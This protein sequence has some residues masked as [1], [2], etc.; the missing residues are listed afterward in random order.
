MKWVCA[1]D[2][3]Q[4]ISPGCSFTFDGLKET[5]L[6]LQPGIEGALSSVSHLSVNYRTTKD[7][8]LLGNEI[9]AVAK[10]TFPN[11]IGFASPEVSRKDLGFK[12]ILCSWA[13]ALKQEVKLGKNQAFIFSSDDRGKAKEQAD[14]WIGLHPFTMS[15]LDSKGL[16]FDDVIVAF[17]IDRKSWKVESKGEMV[18]RMLREL[19]VAVT[20][21]RR[22]VV[23]LQSE[24]DTM[25]NF[26]S[27]LQYDFQTMGAHLVLQEFDSATTP[28]EWEEK[29]KE[30][31][32]DRRFG[33]AARCFE[34]SGN[35]GFMKLAEGKSFQEKG[36][37]KNAKK[38]FRTSI[39][40]FHNRGHYGEALN[41]A[42]RLALSFDWDKADDA[43]VDACMELHASAKERY[44]VVSL[45]LC[46]DKWERIQ[47]DDFR[48]KKT[49]GLFEP[50]RDNLDLKRM[51]KFA[52]ESERKDIGDFLP[53]HIGDFHSNR[54]SHR[55]AVHLYMEG[56]DFDSAETST[57]CCLNRRADRV[58]GEAAEAIVH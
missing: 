3:A 54:G 57:L 32:E 16:E 13:L 39:V 47:L 38:S 20:R 22:R 45:E 19:Y 30:L 11:A 58:Q 55:D 24:C 48:D 25:C 10:K 43:V 4:M 1:G 14:K 17:D 33:D 40:A 52:S 27:T 42:H 53:L 36:D 8:L 23:I 26:F 35:E 21:A 56:G 31:F 5:L 37:K 46:R 41:V 18:L 9:L 50:H 29:G 6:S 49:A 15:S 7:V 44:F 34:K 28:A 12:V 51:I 2:P